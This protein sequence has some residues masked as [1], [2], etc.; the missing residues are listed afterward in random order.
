M[1]QK[2]VQFS[3]VYDICFLLLFSHQHYNFSL[4]NHIFYLITSL[5]FS[6]NAWPLIQ[7]LNIYRYMLVVGSP[8]VDMLLATPNLLKLNFLCRQIFWLKNLRRGIGFK[9]NKSMNKNLV[10]MCQFIF[11]NAFFSYFVFKSTFFVQILENFTQTCVCVC[12]FKKLCSNPKLVSI[13]NLPW[14]RRWGG[15]LSTIQ[16]PSSS[17]SI[18]EYRPGCV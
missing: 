10:K 15:I 7:L 8:K 1:E 9:C 16:V 13:Q 12:N 6:L 2:L 3:L 18:S 4:L 11:L 14:G 17:W 5:L